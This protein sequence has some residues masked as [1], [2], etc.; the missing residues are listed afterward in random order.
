VTT[1]RDTKLPMDHCLS[2]G[3][4]MELASSLENQM[5]SEG[6]TTICIKCGHIMAFDAQLKFRELTDAEMLKIAGDP[7]LI[8]IQKARASVMKNYTK[9][10]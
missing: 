6:A 4:A 2:C 3:H 9:N 8:E 7:E 1:I 10:K 5:P